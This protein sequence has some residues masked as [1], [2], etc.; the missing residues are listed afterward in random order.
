MTP[1]EQVNTSNAIAATPF[2]SSS[3]PII[4]HIPV[5]LD[6]GERRYVAQIATKLLANEPA[7][8]FTTEAFGPLVS[9]GV[10]TGPSLLLQDLEGVA[11]VAAPVDSHLQYRMMLLAQDGDQIALSIRRS[12]SFETYC[13][14]ILNLGQVDIVSPAL[15]APDESLATYCRR[16][17][18]V[19]AKLVTRARQ[20]GCMN[21]K[22]HIGTGAVWALAGTIAAQSGVPVRVA[23]PPPRLT[24]RVN[25]KLWFTRRVSTVLGPRATP[26][27]YFAF[28]PAALTGRVANLVKRYDRVAIKV[29]N[30]S[31]SLGNLTLASSRLRS[32]S[33]RAV[34][35]RLATLLRGLGWRDTYPLMVS[36]WECPVIVSPSVQL[37]IP[38]KEHGDPIVEG[39]FH[40]VVEGPVGEF[41]GVMPSTLPETWRLRLAH[42]SL[43]LGCLLQELG[44][45]GR[46]SFDAIVVGEEL[47]SATLHWIECNGRWGGTSIPMTLA[48]R[49]VGDWSRRPFVVVQQGHLHAPQRD[50][51]VVLDRL[52]DV[53]FRAGQS[54]GG[55]VLLLP[56]RFEN[57]TGL[58]FMVLSETLATARSEAATVTALLTEEVGKS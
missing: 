42:E 7:L 56:G 20:H 49:L 47:D 1:L 58:D 52:K 14:E 5:Q 12:R 9:A 15:S 39:V 51:T 33:I 35:D 53:L 3:L 44:Y 22:P 48:N 36:V 46:C 4:A 23:A 16:D 18:D 38:E 54:G 57:G 30:S 55:V 19:L 32:L 45:F 41:I 25:D 26:P 2:S 17:P 10:D 11:L 28:G 31:G 24:Q 27:S 40:Q 13:R 21:V 34:H 8:R 43:M 37:W 29:P 6:A 50:F